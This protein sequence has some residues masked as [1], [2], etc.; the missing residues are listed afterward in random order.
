MLSKTDICKQHHVTFKINNNMCEG[1]YF[2]CPVCEETLKIRFSKKNKPYCIC[3]DC[4]V[5]LFV[6]GKKGIEK[7][8]KIVWYKFIE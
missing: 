3:D 2:S 5:Q 8:N 7:L 4:G 6:R 1:Y